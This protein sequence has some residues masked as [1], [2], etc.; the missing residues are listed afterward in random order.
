MLSLN[1]IIKGCKNYDKA[2]QHILYEK[3]ALQI[4]SL[5]CRYL[6]NSSDIDDL[7]HDG[8]IKVFVKINQYSGKGSFEGWLKKIF[9]NTAFQYNQKFQRT[10][11]NVNIELLQKNIDDNDLESS[12]EVGTEIIAEFDKDDV[13]ENYLEAVK[14]A[15]FSEGEL[16]NAINEIPEKLRIVF[17]LFCIEEFSHDEIAEILQIDAVTS[18][19]RLLRARKY[20]KKYLYELSLTQNRI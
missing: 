20:L 14:M 9:I 1:D 18:R 7:V 15:D 4:R 10:R 3:Y 2:F 8:F 16:L 11:T 13:P 19:T 12:I 17:N 5:C 6:Y